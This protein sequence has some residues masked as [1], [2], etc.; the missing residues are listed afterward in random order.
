MAQHSSRR[1]VGVRKVE[2][3]D[4]RNII[5][6]RDPDM[7]FYATNRG[8]IWNF[9]DGEIAVAY[10]AV[11]MDYK[12]MDDSY[13]KTWQ[14]H[15][16]GPRHTWNTHERWGSE[17][18]IMLSRSFNYGETW[19]DDQHQW[20]WNNNGTVDEILDWLRP[21]PRHEREEIDLGDNDSIIHFCHGDYLRYPIGNRGT[22]GKTLE[23]KTYNPGRRHHAPSISLRS[24]DRGRTWEG[25]PT[26]IES[27]GWAPDGGYLSV[28]LGHVRFDNGV[29]GIV[30]GVYR[31]NAQC[32]YVSYD[33]G[34]SWEFCS[35][36]VRVSSGIA[37]FGG[38]NEIAGFNYS[39][40]HRLPDGRVMC[41]MH[42]HPPENPCVAFSEDDGMT[43]SEPR[44][45][46][47][48]GTHYGNMSDPLPE[49]PL[50]EAS[51]ANRR[52]CPSALVLRDGRILILFAR[53]TPSPGNRGIVGVMSEDMG[54]TWS[55]EFVVRGD[56]YGWDFGY[57]VLT[58]LPDG[59]IF[60]AYW[61][62]AKDQEEPIQE[63]EVIR[64]VAGT[65][66]RLD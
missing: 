66:F 52:R 48:P 58:E 10:A 51:R 11:P 37:E 35:E 18:G 28:N 44:Y 55:E 30:G 13:N 2:V 43:W 54:E 27:P 20:I 56:A 25:N 5:I 60:T 9:G 57:Q 33:N 39:G 1:R 21:R 34:I 7:Y 31:R 29:L 46:T 42:K 12:T 17:T 15:A 4:P 22:D 47:G 45:V 64:H 16:G 40:V 59:R 14:R 50:N 36:V 8:G 53:R 3:Q 32:Y 38:G 6:H 19:P 65:F 49:R 24:R 41:S 63:P 23:A 61:F 62:C 26:V